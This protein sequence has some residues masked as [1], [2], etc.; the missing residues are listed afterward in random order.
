MKSTSSMMKRLDAL[1]ASGELPADDELRAFAGDVR[2]LVHGAAVGVGDGRNL[3]G[4]LDRLP[5]AIDSADKL[6]G[7]LD[8][9]DLAGCIKEAH[10]ALTHLEKTLEVVDQ[11][12]LLDAQKQEQ[13]RVDTTNALKTLDA[14][15]RRA[16]RLMAA[17][18]EHKGGA[19]KL[20]WDEDAAADLKAVL[21]GVRDDPVKFLLN[22]RA[23]AQ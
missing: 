20:F 4:T 1:L 5:H 16:D 10:V 14:S 11:A 6:A 3:R 8:A 17:V 15:L 2:A 12:P 18:E 23:K 13:L 9:A 22:P 21:K 19:G 7:E